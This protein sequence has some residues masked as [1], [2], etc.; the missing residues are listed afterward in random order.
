M[1]DDALRP[2]GLRI[3]QCSVLAHL[4]KHGDVRVR[5]LAAGLQLEETTLTRNV[6]LLEKEGLVATRAG[7]DRREK[8]LTLTRAGQ[9]TL[10]KAMPLWR[11]VQERLQER[12]SPTTWDAAFRILP[13]IAAHAEPD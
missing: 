6:R 11:A 7:E 10:A 9:E 8:Y 4:N 3:T 12:I 1:Y 5:D 2:V 13:K